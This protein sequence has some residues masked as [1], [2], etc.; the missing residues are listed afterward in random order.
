MGPIPRTTGIWS[1]GAPFT[2][3]Q[4]LRMGPRAA[5]YS[6]FMNRIRLIW[7][8]RIAFSAL[9]SIAA[10]VLVA[11][12]VRSHSCI[13][14]VLLPGSREINL[15]SNQGVGQLDVRLI[16]T[17]Q[18]GWRFI[19]QSNEDLGGPNV[20]FALDFR[21]HGWG[22]QVPYW[23]STLCFVTLAVVSAGG[24]KIRSFG[25]RTLLILTTLTTVVLYLWYPDARFGYEN[26]RAEWGM[27]IPNWFAL[28]FLTSTG[29]A[30]AYGTRIRRFSLR[31]LLIATTLFAV[32]LGLVLW[33]LRQ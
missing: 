13:D 33:L 14:I 7:L 9:C 4:P 2:L 22:I 15:I 21:I 19:S 6:L 11:L 26:N 20:Y 24:A 27:K 5:A 3:D 8:L 1:L 12:C 29:V 23:F 32:M 10:I 18:H 28:L 31:T 17:S 16:P 25:I 30:V